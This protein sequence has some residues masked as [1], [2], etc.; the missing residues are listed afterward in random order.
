MKEFET[1]SPSTK[2]QS[3]R[4]M[5]ADSEN[6][7]EPTFQVNFDDDSDENDTSM[8][9]NDDGMADT[10]GKN[11]NNIN[12]ETYKGNST[13]DHVL[14]QHHSPSSD[15]SNDVYSINNNNT[16]DNSLNNG[17]DFFIEDTDNE[18]NDSGETNNNNNYANGKDKD[19]RDI[20]SAT[21]NNSNTNIP[22]SSSHF[23]KDNTT[24][25]IS[26]MFT[27]TASSDHF[28]KRGTHLRN[29]IKTA[30]TKMLAETTT[31]N[32]ITDG[33]DDDDLSTLKRKLPCQDPSKNQGSKRYKK[34]NQHD[35]YKIKSSSK[36]EEHDLQFANELAREKTAACAI[37][38]RKLQESQSQIS[39][40]QSQLSAQQNSHNQASSKITKTVLALRS[41]CGSTPSCRKRAHASCLAMKARESPLENAAIF[42]HL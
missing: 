25:Q 28:V 29:L 33:G 16:E 38:E 20:N 18:W 37:S 4:T 26:P 11:S 30:L 22:S 36:R 14:K 35:N 34:S 8:A 19:T 23:E 24:D 42:C 3:S 21:Y 27:Q 5:V 12:S 10:A 7:N 32:Y 6:D 2:Q 15:A 41:Q 39:S 13:R 40:L 17:T 1:T 9:D 31:S